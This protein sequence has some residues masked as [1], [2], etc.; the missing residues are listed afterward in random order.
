MKARLLEVNPE[1]PLIEGLLRRIEDLPAE[2][3]ERDPE[4]EEELQEVAS[5]LID[6]ALVRSGFEVPNKNRY[7]TLIKGPR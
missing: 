1:S 3:E 7:E 6:G 2:D 4:I 5:I